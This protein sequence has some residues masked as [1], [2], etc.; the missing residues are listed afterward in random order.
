MPL[1]DLGRV[2]Q[3]I[4]GEIN[5]RALKNEVVELQQALR[6]FKP[7]KGSRPTAWTDEKC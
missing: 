7:K 3:A 5:L 2:S 6:G 1:L 4:G